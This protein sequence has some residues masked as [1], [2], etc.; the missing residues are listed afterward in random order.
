MSVWSVK[1]LACT[2]Q[3]KQKEN[4]QLLLALENAVERDNFSDV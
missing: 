4:L 1:K 2:S 3:T